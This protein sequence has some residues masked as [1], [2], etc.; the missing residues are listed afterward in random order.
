[1]IS[2]VYRLAERDCWCRVCN[3]KLKKQEDKGVFWYSSANR[4]MNI[5]ICPL[6]VKY[7]NKLIEEVI[8]D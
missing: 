5:I 2:P 6:C 1:M 8:S 4:G 3:V 7:L